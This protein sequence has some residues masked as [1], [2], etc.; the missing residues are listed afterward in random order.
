MARNTVCLC[1]SLRFLDD[2]HAANEELTKRGLSVI[3]I[4]LLKGQAPTHSRD[5]TD[6]VHLNKILRSDAVFVVGPGYVGRATARAGDFALPSVRLQNLQQE[7]TFR[8]GRFPTV[9][10][11]LVSRSGNLCSCRCSRLHF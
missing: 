10:R 3:T 4:S 5:L 1:G 11:I 9:S 6:L 2:F 7:G 8:R